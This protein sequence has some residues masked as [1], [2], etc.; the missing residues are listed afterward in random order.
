MLYLLYH[1]LRKMDG[2]L[3]IDFDQ[4][5]GFERQMV[6]YSK[7]FLVHLPIRQK[8]KVPNL[9]EKGFGSIALCNTFHALKP[10]HMWFDML[11]QDAK[12]I[13]DEPNAGG[14]SLYSEVLSVEFLK[15]T[16]GGKLIKT[17]MELQYYPYGGSITDFSY[18]ISGHVVGV[19]VTRAMSFKT[20]YT[21]ENA[22]VLLEKKLNGII[23]SS[24]NVIPKNQW[25]K[26][27][28]HVWA[29]NQLVVETLLTVFHEMS[30]EIRSNTILMITLA[31]NA[32]W[33]FSGAKQSFC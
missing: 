2:V 14:N 32:D 5:I 24:R 18:E 29:Q 10:L 9:I 1:L 25:K 21:E 31:Q 17:E 26:Q 16:F 11:S 28:L 33:I 27:I 12:R 8:S 3:G 7:N 20:L 22:R 6:I 15:R 4:P 19:S 23:V 30:F 13:I